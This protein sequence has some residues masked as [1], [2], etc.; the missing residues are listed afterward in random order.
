MG[1]F[2]EHGLLLLI[3]LD[4]VIV[5]FPQ[6]FSPLTYFLIKPDVDPQLVLIEFVCASIFIKN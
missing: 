6:F 3:Y 5:A 2:L 4:Q 1:Y